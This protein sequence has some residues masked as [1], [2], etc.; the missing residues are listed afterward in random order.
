MGVAVSLVGSLG[1][2]EPSRVKYLV[3]DSMVSEIVTRIKT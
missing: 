1:L 2:M 3:I